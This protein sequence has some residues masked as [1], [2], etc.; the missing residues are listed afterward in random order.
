MDIGDEEKETV[1][2]EPIR[3]P[4]TTPEPK[5]EKDPAPVR[6]PEK[7]PARS[8]IAEGAWC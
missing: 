3:D 7:V 8:Q 1:L 5:P 6:V 2:V 4:L